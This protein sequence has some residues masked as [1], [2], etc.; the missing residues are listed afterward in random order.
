LKNN[1]NDIDVF[2]KDKVDRKR[3]KEGRE[4]GGEWGINVR[5]KVENVLHRGGR[6][7]RIDS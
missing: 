1:A 5:K 3:R 6:R 4:V 2:L 7:G